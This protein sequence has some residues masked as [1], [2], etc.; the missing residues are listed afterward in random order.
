MHLSASISLLH[1]S[2]DQAFCRVP[3]VLLVAVRPKQHNAS[4]ESWVAKEC[5]H[6]RVLTASGAQDPHSSPDRREVKCEGNF[7]GSIVTGELW[8]DLAPNDTK[9]QWGINGR[10]STYSLLRPFEF[11]RAWR[12]FQR[13]K[14]FQSRRRRHLIRIR[15]SMQAQHR[16]LFYSKIFH[17]C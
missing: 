11:K 13:V 2:V 12:F 1:V 3:L 9:V 8:N 5:W 16:Y 6:W 7:N 15:N 17:N 10:T 4:G 14:T